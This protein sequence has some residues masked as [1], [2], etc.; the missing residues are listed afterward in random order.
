MRIAIV[1]TYVSQNGAF[2][3]PVAVASAHAEELARRGH[4]VDFLAGW[5]GIASM[6]IPGVAIRLFKVWRLAPGMSGLA[7]PSLALHMVRNIKRYDVVHVHMGRDLISLPAAWL[8]SKTSPNLFV[9]T[10]GM[11]MPDRRFL[12][13]AL[14]LIGVKPVLGSAKTVFA[15]TA[16]EK[17]GIEQVASPKSPQVDL[18]P[19]G[20]A[21]RNISHARIGARP[22]VLFLAR[23]HPRKRVLAFA[24]AARILEHE[25]SDA[26]FRVVGPD[27]GDLHSLIDFKLENNMSTLDYGGAVP[28]GHGIDEL[29]AASIFV[30]PSVG[31]VFPMTVLES[32]SVGT[33]VVLHTDCAIASELVAIEA[34]EPT[35]GEPAD[36]ARAIN[37]L[38][39]SPELRRRRVD[40]AT[41][42][43]ED[44]LSVEAVVDRLEA[45]YS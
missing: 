18:V 3:G 41:S 40:A 9:Q 36:I 14:D 38:L 2:G 12:A 42:A 45:A 44:W 8:A 17:Q 30:L 16:F 15:L 28:P 10:H 6:S 22:I 32:F 27:E 31:E 11:I 35:N 39:D 5:D 19:N 43:L 7:S 13:R 29:A 25:G 21:R 4:Q 24:E 23:L 1:V 37:L 34:V 20:V 26:I 33:P